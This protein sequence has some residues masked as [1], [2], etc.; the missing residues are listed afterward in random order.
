MND[1]HPWMVHFPIALF[2]MGFICELLDYIINLKIFSKTKIHIKLFGFIWLIPT[3]I[4]GFI[5]EYNNSAGFFELSWN[6]KALV[7]S[8]GFIVIIA[9]ILLLLLYIIRKIIK[10]SF[11]LLFIIIESLLIILLLYGVSIGSRFYH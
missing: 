6:L 9:S 11:I 5:D 7:T 1:I 3:I 10:R 8:H 4:S 2:V